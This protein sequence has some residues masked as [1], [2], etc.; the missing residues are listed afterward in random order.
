M[1]WPTQAG[2]RARRIF[3][4]RFERLCSIGVHAQE[5]EQPQRVRIDVDLYLYPEDE[6]AP[7]RD[8]IDSVLD[9]DF[10]RQE[11]VRLTT[12]RHFDLQETLCGELLEACLARV[13]VRGARVSTEKPD[14]Y[15][16]CEAVGVEFIAFK[17]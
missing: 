14:V 7:R 10:V 16:D 13:E 6:S 17:S 3:V 1:H 15:P 2:V 9:Y 12:G 11:I 4:R 5:R 8:E